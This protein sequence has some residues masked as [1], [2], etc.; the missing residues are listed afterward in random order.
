MLQEVADDVQEK[1]KEKKPHK[2][3]VA[4]FFK[5]LQRIENE[6][7]N[8]LVDLGRSSVAAVC[9]GKAFD[10]PDSKHVLY[11]ALTRPTKYE[12]GRLY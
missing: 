8:F 11:R 3:I 6:C 10:H 4:N 5:R 1:V 2:E 9:A 7:W 12:F